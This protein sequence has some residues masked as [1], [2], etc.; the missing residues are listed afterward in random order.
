MLMGRFR[1]VGDALFQFNDDDPQIM[2]PHMCGMQCMPLSKC[3]AAHNQVTQRHCSEMP[4][5]ERLYEQ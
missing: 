1:L 4:F 2:V 5:I 3:A